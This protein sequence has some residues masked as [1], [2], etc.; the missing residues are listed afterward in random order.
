[1]LSCLL[2]DNFLEEFMAFKSD[3]D[4]EVKE[5][6]TDL[7]SLA[8]SAQTKPKPQAGTK[9]AASASKWNKNVVPPSGTAR[10][11]EKNLKRMEVAHAKDNY[12]KPI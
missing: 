10:L 9:A 7:E 4:K 11:T 3:W 1:M 5:R 2:L 6:G 12:V 8:T